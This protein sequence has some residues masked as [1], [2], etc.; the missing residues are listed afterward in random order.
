MPL[1]SGGEMIPDSNE[2]SVDYELHAA[3]RDNTLTN[4]D[5]KCGHTHKHMDSL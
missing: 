4:T 1:E 2:E 5:G 3:T